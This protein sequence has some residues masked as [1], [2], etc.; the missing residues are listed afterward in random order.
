MDVVKEDLHGPHAGSAAANPQQDLVVLLIQHLGELAGHPDRVLVLA[1]V[2]GHAK[3]K[4]T[5]GL[6]LE[7]RGG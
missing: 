7:C 2:E 6:G 1:V 5:I 4:H 3:L